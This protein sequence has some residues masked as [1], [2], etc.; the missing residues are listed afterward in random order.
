MI[1][2]EVTLSCGKNFSLFFRGDREV[3]NDTPVV[4]ARFLKYLSETYLGAEIRIKQEHPPTGTTQDQLELRQEKAMWMPP[5]NLM[6]VLN[7]MEQGEKTFL[8]DEELDE[9]Q[10]YEIAL[11]SGIREVV[12]VPRGLNLALNY[13]Q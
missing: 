2:V 5:F 8:D 4:A 1:T 7:A 10:I 3:G 11:N 13:L 6:R 12:R 9:K